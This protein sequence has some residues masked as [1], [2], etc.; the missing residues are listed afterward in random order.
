MTPESIKQIGTLFRQRRQQR[1]WSIRQLAKRSHVH[2]STI[3]RLEQGSFL[4]PKDDTLERVATALDISQNELAEISARY[5]IPSD[6]PELGAYLRTKYP[7]L[8]DGAVTELLHHF[9]RL[10]SAALDQT[11]A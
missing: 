1:G 4:H 9:T 5:M 7:E 3:T 10:R 6:L 8:S 2:A 11:A